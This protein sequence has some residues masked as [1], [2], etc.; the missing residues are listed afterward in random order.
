AR[1]PGAAVER[2]RSG[3]RALGAAR[4]LVVVRTGPEDHGRRLRR[5]VHDRPRAL[6]RAGPAGT[7]D[8]AAQRVAG[9]RT[10]QAADGGERR[11]R[12]R[13]RGDVPDADPAVLV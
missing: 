8:P 12:V 5:G 6:A 13:V 1:A 4:A 3:L 2:P 11:R 7:G 10:D 9:L